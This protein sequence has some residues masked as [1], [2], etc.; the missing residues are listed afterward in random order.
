MRN[1]QNSKIAGLKKKEDV[2]KKLLDRF[3]EFN[4]NQQFHNLFCSYDFHESEKSLLEFWKDVIEFLFESIKNTHGIKL[5]EMLDYIKIK[6]KKPLCLSNITIKLIEEGDLI[7]SSKLSNDD[8]YKKYFNDMI[9]IKDT[10]GKWIK[11]NIS[12]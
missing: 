1:S 5:E 12:R 6:G 8:Y 4:D 7:P 11:K 10:W 2:E 9:N 3:P